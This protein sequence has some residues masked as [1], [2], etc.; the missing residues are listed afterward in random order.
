MFTIIRP[1]SALLLAVFA[2]YAAQA[3]EPIYDPQADLGAFPLWAAGVSALVGWFFL[4]GRIGRA[5]WYS[6]F[7]AVQAVVLAAIA[8]AGF[9]AVGDVFE[10]GYRRQYDE[11]MEAITGYFAIVVDWLGRA[12]VQDFVILLGVG[13]I[14]IG[15]VL[16]ILWRMMERRRNAR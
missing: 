5:L 12:L 1:I 13:G 4:G 7:V 11:V 15:V 8:T 16:H 2:L 10:R 3:Y 14:G 6:V 9:L